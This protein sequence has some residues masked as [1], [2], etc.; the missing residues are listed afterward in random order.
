MTTPDHSRRRFLG[1]AAWAT[2]G[3]TALGGTRSFAQSAPP[4]NMPSITAIPDKLKG[5][6]EVRI[7]AY[8]GT[9]QDAERDRVFRAVRE[10]E[11]HQDAR[12]PRCRHQQGEGDGGYRQC[13]MGRRAARPLHRKEPDE[14]GR[15]LREDRLRPGRCGQHRSAVSLRL[16]ARH[17]GMVAGD[18]VSHRCVQGRGAER[19]GGFLGREE[20]PRRPHADRCRSQAHRN[21]S[22]H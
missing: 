13:R 6:G 14:E 17:V 2:A 3:M 11:R 4:P 20:V 10:A 19:L 7:A 18:G 22:S 8:G 5:S 21:S 1:L 16:R 15:L 9:A 12:L